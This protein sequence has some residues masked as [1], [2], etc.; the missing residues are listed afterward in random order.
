MITVRCS[1]CSNPEI[2]KTFF[3]RHDANKGIDNVRGH[4]GHRELQKTYTGPKHSKI[5]A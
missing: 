1:F 5:P 2:I 3:K 4:G